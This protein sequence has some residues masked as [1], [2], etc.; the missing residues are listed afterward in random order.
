MH[1]KGKTVS[2]ADPPVIT[3][4]AGVAGKKEGEG[5]LSEDFDAV[6]ADTTMGQ[7]S[8]E[9][10]ESAMLRDAILRALSAAGK[11]PSDVDFILS[12]DLLDQCM[13]S[14][15]AIKDLDIPAIGLYGAC[16]TMALS[17][18]VG[19]MLIDAGAKCCVAGTS[20]H[21]CSSERQFRFPL[22]YGGQRPP[23]AQWTVTGAGS[24][25]LESKGEGVRIRAVHIGTIT[26][27]GITDA[28]NMGAAMAP[29]AARTIHDLLEDSAT[30]PAD[31]D[32]IVTGDL[33]AV[34]TKLLYQLMERD[35][36]IQLA[37]HHKDCGMMI[38]DLKSQDVN[39]GGSGCG[40]GGAVQPY[41]EEN[42][43]G[44]AAQGTVCGHRCADVAH[45]HQAGQ[46]H[47]RRGPRRGIGG[48]SV[49]TRYVKDIRVLSAFQ[50]T[51]RAMQILILVLRVLA[52][53]FLV[54]QSITLMRDNA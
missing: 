54:L 53:A 46:L 45:Q 4:H 51:I 32:Q 33:G 41:F 43:A 23:S 1:K 49:K 28:G 31:Y 18:G 52:V 22:E 50:Q 15:F 44:C 35:W 25:V 2:F 5:P 14:A 48:V 7:Q 47:S 27:Y 24:A 8:F 42:G 39:A 6:F 20:S 37:G 40:W 17:L 29:A 21:F 34:G 36:G 10:A 13:G 16:S 26:D 38:Y 3:G 9:L 12:G 11:S 19:A 30:T